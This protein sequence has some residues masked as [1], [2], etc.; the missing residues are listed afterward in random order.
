VFRENLKMD[1][2]KL[3]DDVM[4]NSKYKR[5]RRNAMLETVSSKERQ[6]T[7]K[8]KEKTDKTKKFLF[9]QL[10]A[11]DLL[12]P[13][14]DG[15]LKAMIGE[16]RVREFSKSVDIIKEG[17]DGDE[18]FVLEEGKIEVYYTE[19]D[20]S[21][22]K[23]R[24]MEAPVTFGEIA[25]LFNT[26]RTATI[27]ATSACLAWTIDRY[28]FS[29]IVSTMNKNLYVERSAFL[30]EIK[31][32]SNLSDY[33]IAK[34][35]NIATDG[36][37]KKDEFVVKEGES[38]ET[39]FILTS[40]T[41]NVYQKNSKRESVLINQMRSGDHFGEKA[42]KNESNTRTASVQVVSKSAV[43]LIIQKKDVNRLIG[44]IEEVYPD[45]PVDNEVR[46][47]GKLRQSIE[48]KDLHQI[49]ILGEGGFGKVALVNKGTQFYAQ[50]QILKK[51]T[52]MFEMDLEKDIMTSGNCEF[53]VRLHGTLTD[54]D[55]YYFLMEP[56]LG[57]DLMGLLTSKK[58]F[59]E[60]M[61]KF[62]AAGL[63]ESL[64]FLHKN[65]I[66]YRD[67]KPENIL[68][69]AKGYPKLSDFGLA[70]R[71]PPGEKRYTF[72]GTPEYMA[73]EVLLKQGHDYSV[74]LWA[75][76]IFIYEMT[77][78][79]SPFRDPKETI[80]GINRVKFTKVISTNCQKIIT[81]FCATKPTQRLGY[82]KSGYKEIRHHPWFLK[83]DWKTFR[84]QEL[85]APWTP[86]LGH[87]MDTKYFKKSRYR[88]E[89]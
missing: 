7:E 15:Q 65:D 40:G 62:Y 41:C 2:L 23:L 75:L 48:L 14:V 35:A 67:I 56:C 53:I 73:P 49:C 24:D 27:K 54:L 31:F 36:E 51:K 3:S 82:S 66:V 17:D 72:C 30:R 58:G 83:F 11:C 76:G 42:I 26:P 37:Y 32:L 43:C 21:E 8:L 1:K 13:L 68:I 89:T 45:R 70:R 44:N 74:D 84:A 12:S 5:D 87:E 88:S 33:D 61:S 50:K 63:I 79:E 64:R 10:R 78:G 69:D 29:S 52:N 6:S 71:T 34:I 28:V 57:G 18:I 55:Y 77:Q 46:Q 85:K 60:T 59:S 20:G 16:M 86:N 38:G 39:F 4:P 80:K 19:D 47:N 81:E 22:C 9:K 25:L